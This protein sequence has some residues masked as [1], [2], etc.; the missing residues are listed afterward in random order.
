MKQRKRVTPRRAQATIFQL[1]ASAEGDEGPLRRWQQRRRYKAVK[2]KITLYVDADVVDWFKRAGC[3]Y[4]TR[5]NR[6]LWKVMQ[7]EKKISGE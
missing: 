1:Q 3:G 5:I 4:Q 7:E 2:K 6:A